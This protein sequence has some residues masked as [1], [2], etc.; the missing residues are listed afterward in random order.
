MAALYGVPTMLRG[1]GPLELPP[2]RAGLLTHGAVLA[3]YAHPEVGSPTLRGRFVRTALLCDT[4]PPPPDDVGEIPEVSEDAVTLRERLAEH[5]ENPSCAGCHA[6][7]DPIGL[8]LENFDGIGA[9]R[10]TENGA[11]IDASG[12]LDGAEYDDAAGLGNALADH[13]DLMTCFVRNF[14]R[15][16]TGHIETPGETRSILL[17]A[18]DFEDS[19]FIKAL[20]TELL[21]SEGFRTAGEPQ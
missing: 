21:M 20:L 16:A 10:E 18:R 6:R 4:I 8:A 19:G 1:F 11:V 14:Y 5:R 15:Y 12:E 17:L 9:Y 7:M 13:P 3:S 2:E